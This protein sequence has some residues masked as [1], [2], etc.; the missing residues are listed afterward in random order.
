MM[1]RRLRI[2]INE[3]RRRDRVSRRRTKERKKK[4]E[5]RRRNLGRKRR[6]RRLMERLPPKHRHQ[7]RSRNRLVMMDLLI[8]KNNL[9]LLLMRFQL[10][11]PQSRKNPRIL[12]KYN[13]TS[14]L[15]V[16]TSLALSVLKLLILYGR[17]KRNLKSWRPSLKVQMRRMKLLEDGMID[18]LLVDESV[19]LDSFYLLLITIPL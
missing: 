8:P 7:L 4:N 13:Y 15:I 1:I 12:L 10:K 11:L 18:F 14:F 17:M 5:F 16:R 6:F 19:C 3:S 9:Y 2:N